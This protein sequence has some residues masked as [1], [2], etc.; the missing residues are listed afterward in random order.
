MTG[1]DSQ[2]ENRT[3]IADVSRRGASNAL[4]ES[5]RGIPFPR[6]CRVSQ[7]GHWTD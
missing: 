4:S 5:A 7:R 2:R 1:D 6:E 3:K